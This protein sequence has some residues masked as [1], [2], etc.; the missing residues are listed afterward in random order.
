MLLVNK[1]YKKC[2]LFSFLSFNSSQFRSSRPDVFC[3][4]GALKKAFNF[5]V[6]E[7]LAQV[8]SYEFYEISKNIFS[9]RTPQVA[10]I[11]HFRFRLVFIKVYIFVQQ[12]AWAKTL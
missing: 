1:R 10:G 2:T 7:T 6:I 9:Y 8:F 5:I 3:K 4:K 11:F 12:K